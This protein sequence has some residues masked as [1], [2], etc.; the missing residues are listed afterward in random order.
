[1]ARPFTITSLY[2]AGDDGFRTFE[3]VEDPENVS[4]LRAFDH[5]QRC[6]ALPRI[7]RAGST[8]GGWAER[9]ALFK[10]LLAQ[11]RRGR[12]VTDFVYS[13]ARRGGQMR[14]ENRFCPNE[15]AGQPLRGHDV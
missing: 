14:K 8:Q 13:S 6:Q 9:K 3:P 12:E 1:M 11:H 5:S 4:I 10:F 15:G 7:R 2:D